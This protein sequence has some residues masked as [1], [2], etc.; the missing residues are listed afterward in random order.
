MN[1]KSIWNEAQNKPS[2]VVDDLEHYLGPLSCHPRDFIYEVLLRRGVFKWFAVRRGIIKLKDKWKKEISQSIDNQKEHPY[3][4]TWHY[5]KGYRKAKEECR[6][7]I[8]ALCHSDR[9]QA[10]D[11]DSRAKK[12][13]TSRSL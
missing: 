3:S 7:E 11:N 13:L 12:W 5:W 4:A 2:L 10:P 1:E 8:R 9:W 6:A